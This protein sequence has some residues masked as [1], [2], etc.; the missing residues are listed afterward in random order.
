MGVE[1]LRNSRWLCMAHVA[2]LHSEGLFALQADNGWKQHCLIFN[3]LVGFVH[4]CCQHGA[5]ARFQCKHFR[6][7]NVGKLPRLLFVWH[8]VSSV[9]I[10]KS[11][12][13]RM[14][15]PFV[16]ASSIEDGRRKTEDGTDGRRE[17]WK[18]L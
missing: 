14:Y 10:R 7:C 9:A 2:P 13:N 16:G 3:L 5:L 18:T 1:R 4:V 15:T 8:H 12:V 17:R 11:F 6:P